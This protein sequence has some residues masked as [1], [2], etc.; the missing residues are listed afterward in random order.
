MISIVTV[1]RLLRRESVADADFE[2]LCVIL[3]RALMMIVC[4]IE[5]RFPHRFAQKVK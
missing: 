1:I 4:W 3:H 2:E 5:R